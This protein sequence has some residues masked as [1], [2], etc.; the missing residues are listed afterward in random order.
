MEFTERLSATEETQEGIVRIGDEEFHLHLSILSEEN[1]PSKRKLA[2]EKADCFV[3]AFS[4]AKKE[5]LRH[6]L[7][8]WMSEIDKY[9]KKDTLYEIPKILCGT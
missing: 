3:L 8:D 2:I 1:R 7:K 6:I 9:K 4:L 5:T